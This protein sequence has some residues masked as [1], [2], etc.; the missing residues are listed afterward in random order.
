MLTGNRLFFFLFSFLFIGFMFL[1][2]PEESFS[3]VAQPL[4]DCCQLEGQC[5]DLVEGGQACTIEGFVPDAQCNEETGLCEQVV[6]P[7]AIPTLNE[8]GLITVAMA[9]GILG[10]AGIVVYRRR[11]AS[12]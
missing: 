12:A 7:S 11:R 6:F 5:F 9:L 4:G 10:A 2:L 8:W 1:S 3:G